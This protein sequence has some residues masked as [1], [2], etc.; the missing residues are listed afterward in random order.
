MAIVVEDGTGKATAESYISVTDADTYFLDRNV[1]AW[2]DLDYEEKEASLRRATEYM[3]GAFRSR[4]RG[5]RV[6]ATVQALDWPRSGVCVDDRFIET[7]EIPVEVKRSCAELALRASTA[8][9]MTDLS[10]GV[11]SESVGPISV[12]YDKN[13]SRMVRYASVDAALAPYLSGSG[14]VMVSMVR[15]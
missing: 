6:Y 13:S 14:G 12:T 5:S 9:L 15:A 2:D 11:V 1:T 4:W 7:D 10:Q 3:T 8:D